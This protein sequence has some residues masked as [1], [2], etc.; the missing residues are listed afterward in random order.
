VTTEAEPNA[1]NGL[2]LHRERLMAAV[3]DIRPFAKDAATRKRLQDIE[4]QIRKL[5]ARLE[6]RARAVPRVEPTVDPW[7]R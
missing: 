2:A 1:D 4:R 6:Q 3:S 5:D 7:C